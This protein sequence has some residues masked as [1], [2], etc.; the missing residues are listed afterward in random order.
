MRSTGC[1]TRVC[2][3]IRRWRCCW[4]AV[5]NRS[6]Q[7]MSDRYGDSTRA[8][9]AVSSQPIPGEPVGPGPVFASA[10]HLSD[11]EGSEANT[12]GRGSNPTWRQLESALAQLEGATAALSFGS[13][14]AAITA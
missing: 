1:A 8:V 11:D 2:R 12:Y 3:S 14:M 7:A 6:D 13:G 9:K 10:F 5:S 4:A